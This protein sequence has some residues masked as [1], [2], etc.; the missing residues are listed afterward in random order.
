MRLRG[1][2]L[3]H[4]KRLRI[5]LRREQLDLVRAERVAADRRSFADADVVITTI[6]R[7][8]YRLEPPSAR[9]DP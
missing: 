2:S 8:G 7:V 6:P 4:V 5:E 9:T 3:V 1:R